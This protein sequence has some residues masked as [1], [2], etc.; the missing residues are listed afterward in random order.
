MYIYIYNVISMCI[1]VYK[2]VYITSMNIYTYVFF[3]V[4]IAGPPPLR[5]FGHLLWRH[6]KNF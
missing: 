2:C 3:A 1:D 5:H 6:M 4:C